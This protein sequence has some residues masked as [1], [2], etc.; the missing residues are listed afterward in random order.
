M[1]LSG[2]GNNV[3]ANKSAK[4]SFWKNW[5]SS[6][7]LTECCG[8]IGREEN[9]QP[10]WRGGMY[11]IEV[12]NEHPQWRV[13]RQVSW[14]VNV[15]FEVPLQISLAL[16]VLVSSMCCWSKIR[17]EGSMALV[18]TVNLHNVSICERLLRNKAKRHDGCA[19]DLRVLPAS[20]RKK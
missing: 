2:F 3:F 12:R 1:T 11:A 15:W 6:G 19:A 18:T 8:V 4:S 14:H 13:M 7:K 16:T 20:S 5:L 9:L 17:I 10:S